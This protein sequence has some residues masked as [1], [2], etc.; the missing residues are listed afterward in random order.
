M[1]NK[2]EREVIPLYG[3]LPEKISLHL[4]LQYILSVNEFE[5]EQRWNLHIV[6]DDL[7]TAKELRESW[8]KI[9]T[10]RHELMTLQG[11][12][13]KQFYISLMSKLAEQ[14]ETSSYAVLAKDLNFDAITY[15]LWATDKDLTGVQKK[16]GEII[17]INLFHALGFKN[18]ALRSWEMEARGKLKAGKAPWGITNGPITK[19]RVVHVLEQFKKKIA[20]NKHIFSTP[21]DTSHIEKVWEIAYIKGYWIKAEKLLQKENPADLAKYN[22]RLNSRSTCLIQGMVRK[23]GLNN[24]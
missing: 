1:K 19:N 5:K 8:G 22:E 3:M 14:K 18:N 15:L 13:P 2:V 10:A 7:T 24:E 12:D 11:P 21:P 4:W 17:F 6:L 23:S 16:A 20:E 9:A